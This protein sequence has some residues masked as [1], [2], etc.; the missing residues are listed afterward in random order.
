[1]V[2]LRTHNDTLAAAERIRPYVH[3]TP[4]FT[5]TMLNRMTGTEL[6]FTLQAVQI[7]GDL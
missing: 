3:R 1:V 4:M 5:S 7:L 6:S 2:T